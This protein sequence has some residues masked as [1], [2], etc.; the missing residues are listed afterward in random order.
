MLVALCEKNPLVEEAL[1]PSNPAFTVGSTKKLS[2][3]D[4]SSLSVDE[5]WVLRE[6]VGA[7]LTG[8]ISGELRVLKKRLER[9]KAEEHGKAPSSGKSGSPSSRKR[10]PY[11]P[12]LPKFQNPCD[13]SEIWS[14]RGK[15]PRWLIAQLDQGKLLDDF[16]V[17]TGASS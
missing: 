9:L 13:L 1:L 16:R 14:G 10:R 12:V 17:S 4:L 15:Q 5:L 8:R 2:S 11:P 6:Q 3:W 7:L